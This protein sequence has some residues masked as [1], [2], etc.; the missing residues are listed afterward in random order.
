MSAATFSPDGKSIVA[1][2]AD[3]A[4]GGNR[5][6]FFDAATRARRRELAVKHAPRGIAFVEG[7]RRLVTLHADRASTDTGDGAATLDLWDTST[8]RPVGEP[9]EFPA[10]ADA[11]SSSSNRAVVATDAGF[12]VVWDLDP[13]HWATMACRI[14]GRSLTS[15]EWRQYLPGRPYKPA[16][17]AQAR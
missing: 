7:G 9:L 12:A 1:G 5:I 4:E 13:N 10:G 3:T 15:E 8:L 2:A 6:V 14:A 17:D 16:C 11:V